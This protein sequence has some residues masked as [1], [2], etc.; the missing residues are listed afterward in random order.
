[1]IHVT[2]DRA[3]WAAY[4]WGD[5]DPATVEEEVMLSRPLALNQARS[6]TGA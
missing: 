3:V 1:M 6:Q 5:P 2:F 4:G